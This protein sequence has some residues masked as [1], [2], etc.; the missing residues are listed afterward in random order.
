MI[1][2]LLLA[3]VCSGAYGQQAKSGAA[4]L[5]LAGGYPLIFGVEHNWGSYIYQKPDG[6]T[7]G[8]I[9]DI[10]KAVCEAK[11]WNCKITTD[12]FA[13][14]VS[15]TGSGT[16]YLGAGVENQYYT[17]YVGCQQTVDR[18]EFATFSAKFA[19]PAVANVYKARAKTFDAGDFSAN[20]FGFVQ[21]WT[22]SLSCLNRCI[23]AN[24]AVIAAAKWPL[25]LATNSP[26]DGNCV[27]DSS[28]A[29]VAA[30]TDAASP[31]NA[32]LLSA[33]SVDN[34]TAVDLVMECR[35]TTAGPGVLTR[36][37]NVAWMDKWNTGFG[38][39]VT[40]G[41]YAELCNATNKARHED[42]TGN[43]IDCIESF[44]AG[45]FDAA[46]TGY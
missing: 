26:C 11:K 28:T 17:G 31:I 18:N 36:F 32:M 6:G 14:A 21:G 35:C 34:D 4:N 37:D 44:V 12:I 5:G 2:I 15:K 8:F 45:T 38:L 24:T 10:I 3:L 16:L 42:I 13:N 33:K 19:K 39:V 23:K 25:K 22:T 41:I 1:G 43:S 7:D 46:V 27:F 40:S 20:K 9:V 29:L 30:I